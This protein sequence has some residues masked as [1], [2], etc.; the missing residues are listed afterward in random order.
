MDE[1]NKEGE[2]RGRGGKEWEGGMEGDIGKGWGWR[3]FEGGREGKGGRNGGG[4]GEE[5]ELNREKWRYTKLRFNYDLF[6]IIPK[7]TSL[8]PLLRL[9]RPSPFPTPPPSP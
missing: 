6:C 4:V 3:E 8:L 2:L 7:I 9:F 5:M 1:G